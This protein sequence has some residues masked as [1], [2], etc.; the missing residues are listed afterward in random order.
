MNVGA[1]KPVP[2][3]IAG[4]FR[5]RFDWYMNKVIRWKQ[6]FQNFESAYQKLEN[7][8]S[9]ESYSEI[10]GAGFIQF[11]EFT[12]ELAWKTLKDYLESEG[13]VTKSPR[14]VF[15]QA[16][17]VGL[18]ADGHVW[19]DALED[20]NLLAHTYDEKTSLKVQSL[21]KKKYFP[22]MQSLY[23]VLKEKLS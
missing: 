15:K 4:C 20:R 7:A 3:Q 21:I 17:Q 8:A 5:P 11:F 9:Q 12:F 19:M 16:F 14:E 22:A 2:R 23:H 6:R 13:Y 10:E 1:K 18:L